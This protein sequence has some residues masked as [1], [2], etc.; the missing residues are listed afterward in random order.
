[1]TLT[2]CRMGIMPILASKLLSAEVGRPARR[3]KDRALS[4]KPRHL[5]KLCTCYKIDFFAPH[6]PTLPNTTFTQFGRIGGGMSILCHRAHL[7]SVL[8]SGKPGAVQIYTAEARRMDMRP[9]KD[10]SGRA[11]ESSEQMSLPQDAKLAWKNAPENGAIE[12]TDQ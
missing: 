3:S 12:D 2:V 11:R 9:D 5:G 1:M 4:P 10:C 6:R 8:L 7:L